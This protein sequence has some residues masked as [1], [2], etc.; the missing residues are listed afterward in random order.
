[1]KDLRQPLVG[2]DVVSIAR[3]A[4]LAEGKRFSGRIFTG[5]E[6]A[7]ARGRSQRLAAAFAVKEAVRKVFGSAGLSPLPAFSAIELRH[8][9]FGAPSVDVMGAPS[10]CSVSISHTE[11]LAV[12]VVVME[13]RYANPAAWLDMDLDTQSPAGLAGLSC[14][15]PD[16]PPEGHKGTFGT[17]LVIGGSRGLSGAPY[18]AAMGAARGG[19]GMVRLLVPQDIYSTVAAKCIEV[20]VHPVPSDSDGH[21]GDG[22]IPVVDGQLHGVSAVVIGPGLGTGLPAMRLLAHLLEHCSVPV[23]VDADGLNLVAKH[24]LAWGTHMGVR[25]GTP[26][27]GEMA[28]LLGKTVQDV[29]SDR[30]G[31]ASTYADKNGI[32]MVLKGSGTV[33]ASSRTSFWVGPH[34]VVTLAT[35]GSGDVLAGVLGALVA[36]PG[37]E[38][39]RIVAG[40]AIHAVA[41][42]LALVDR[43]V[44]GVIA[45]D[46][47]DVLP[48]AQEWLRAQLVRQHGHG[49]SRDT[50]G[51]LSG[52]FGADNK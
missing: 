8:D 46:L 1:V 26:H 47:L 49:A 36:P 25:I 32:V 34:G 43:G 17:V 21:V 20:M 18:L 12:A 11:G 27:P 2:I 45:S 39:G 33:V 3:V 50:D 22:V 4:R 23:V 52:P 5:R 40:V 30:I 28:R 38:P 31:A 13:S 42:R 51:H 37:Y 7:E 10:G 9:D 24:G 14:R 16:R 48:A 15:L 35:G 44:A 29:E 19:A 6:L 41:G